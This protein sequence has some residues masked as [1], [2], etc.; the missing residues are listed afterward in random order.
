MTKVVENNLYLGRFNCK[1]IKKYRNGDP[2]DFVNSNK[3]W[4][5]C[6]VCRPPKS[7]NKPSL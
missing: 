1:Q 4:V 2:G 6:S 7:L 3:N 5:K